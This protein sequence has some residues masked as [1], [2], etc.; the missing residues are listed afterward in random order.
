MT[1][2]LNDLIFIGIIVNAFVLF[3][4]WGIVH[5]H[6][7]DRIRQLENERDWWKDR[8]IEAKRYTIR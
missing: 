2:F 4:I 6:Y 3:G 1:D 5:F 8:V 7:T